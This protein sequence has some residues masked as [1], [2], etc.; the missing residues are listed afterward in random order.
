MANKDLNYPKVGKHSLVYE[1]WSKIMGGNGISGTIRTVPQNY[2]VATVTETGKLIF[3]NIEACTDGID[4]DK[5]KKLWA[6]CKIPT[7]DNFKR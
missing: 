2:Y 1:I 7:N 6:Y 5:I 3:E 4:E